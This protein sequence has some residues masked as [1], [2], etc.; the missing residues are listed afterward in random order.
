VLRSGHV[1]GWALALL[2]AEYAVHFSAEGKV[3][4]EITPA[5]AGGFLLVGEL[6]FWS[7]ESRV[8]AWSEPGL[9]GRR[10]M[11]VIASGAAATCVAAIA[12]VLAAASGGGGLAL[13]AGGVAAAIGALVLLAV[14]VR[15][16][17]PEVDS[18]A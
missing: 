18:R 10:L 8:A 11:Y 16:S 9:V 12:L 17:V 1:V 13:E 2:G 3:L 7:I 15:R 5:Y 6:A 14:L 4:D